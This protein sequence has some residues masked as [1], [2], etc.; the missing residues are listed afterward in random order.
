MNFGHV[1]VFPFRLFV[2]LRGSISKRHTNGK[3]GGGLD[4]NPISV[5]PFVMKKR[6]CLGVILGCWGISLS[7]FSLSSLSVQSDTPV[8]V[9]VDGKSLG[10]TP[11]SDRSVSSGEHLIRYQNKEAGTQMEFS[12]QF[13]EGKAVFCD[14]SLS[15]QQNRCS[16]KARALDSAQGKV[17]FLSKPEAVVWVDGKRVGRT[18]IEARSFDVGTH[19]VEFRI[20]GYES[21]FETVDLSEGE[22][23]K[24][25]V[26]F[27][28]TEVLEE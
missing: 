1:L 13:I 15:S 25:S 6:L 26:E 9:F 21:V 3:L 19:K 11:L 10:L 4:R 17:T 16:Q 20:D 7:A 22:T 5:T 14:Y 8:E 18:P 23:K 12:L 27:Q 2:A 24:L 28:T